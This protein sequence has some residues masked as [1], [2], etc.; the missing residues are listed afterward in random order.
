M[1]FYKSYFINANILIGVTFD[2]I[3]IKI[4]SIFE[5]SVKELKLI[6]SLKYIVDGNVLKV[7][8]IEVKNYFQN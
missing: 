8:N 3:S 7:S 1:L 4:V 2:N 6:F 5:K